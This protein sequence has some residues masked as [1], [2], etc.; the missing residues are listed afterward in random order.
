MTGPPGIRIVVRATLDWGDEAAV[1]AGLRDD[2]RPKYEM[3]NRTFNVPYHRF[4]QRLKAL[5]EGTLQGVSGAQVVV[6]DAI[7]AGAL[8]VPVDDDDWFAPDL[9]SRLA[10]AFDGSA[11]GYRWPSFIL[12]AR[13]MGNPLRW[14]LN[15]GHPVAPAADDSRF[16]CT[17]NNYAFVAGADA[18]ELARSHAEASRRFD[19]RPGEVRRLPFALSLQNRNLASQT[20][21]A[22]GQPTIARS[23]LLRRYRRYRS[24]YD[25][26]D[27]PPELSWARPCVD[28]M[29]DLMRELRPR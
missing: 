7:A 17:S 21:L 11:F 18:R 1:R 20:A 5:A 15:R 13:P 12:E 22:W 14:L 29:R 27:L 6:P 19:A 25:R 9:A 23:K 4:R 26:V 8:V 16:T 2:F 10:A 24:L 3:W 28:A